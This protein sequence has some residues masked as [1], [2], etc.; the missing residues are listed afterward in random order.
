MPG[1]TPSDTG[2]LPPPRPRWSGSMI[3]TVTADER[4][5]AL[6]AMAFDPDPVRRRLE[7]MLLGTVGVGA[8]DPL[9]DR[10][11]GESHDL[12][13]VIARESTDHAF[14]TRVLAQ[15]AIE[16]W[17]VASEGSAAS[18]TALLRAAGAFLL[19]DAATWTALG[20]RVTRL[21]DSDDEPAASVPEPGATEPQ[22]AA[23]EGDSPA[24]TVPDAESNAPPEPNVGDSG[25]ESG[26]E[27]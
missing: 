7:P 24:P 1:D 25:P 17:S 26:R 16:V 20:R 11:E 2:G 27:G 4:R 22:L 8:I 9:G 13:L 3:E 12:A 18:R 23:T 5:A 10:Y 21:D 15:A 14:E 19:H 6:E